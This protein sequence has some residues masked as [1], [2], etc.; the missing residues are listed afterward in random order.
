[1]EQMQLAHIQGGRPGF[2]QHF[3]DQSG[4]W[5]GRG[6]G[7]P[8]GYQG[9]GRGRG[10]GRGGQHPDRSY[11]DES[12]TSVRTVPTESEPSQN[13]DHKKSLQKNPENQSMYESL[14]CS[15]CT[16]LLLYCACYYLFVDTS[17]YVSVRALPATRYCCALATVA[18]H[19]SLMIA[20]VHVG[21]GASQCSH[22]RC[23]MLA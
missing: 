9:R 16:L 2:H 7:G 13:N 5:V 18:T 3:S 20:H 15:Y 23:D 12:F 4:Y 11:S 1:M 21:G 22:S 14:C 6:Q 10:G 19:C 8:E 17:V